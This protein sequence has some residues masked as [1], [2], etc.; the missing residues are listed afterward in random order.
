M[1]LLFSF[2]R[3]NRG[4]YQPLVGPVWSSS[5]DADWTIMKRNHS[6]LCIPV[7]KYIKGGRPALTGI[8]IRMRRGTKQP[9]GT[10]VYGHKGGVHV[11]SGSW[12]AVGWGATSALKFSPSSP[13]EFPSDRLTLLLVHLLKHW[14]FLKF[15]IFPQIVSHIFWC[16]WGFVGDHHV[17][18]A[19]F[20]RSRT[21][22]AVR[23]RRRMGGAHICLF[24]ALSVLLNEICAFSEII[25]VIRELF[26]PPGVGFV[27]YVMYYGQ[28]NSYLIHLF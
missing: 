16:T 22:T 7:S 13:H 1:Y 5:L 12:G 18:W 19:S 26:F 11:W 10:W 21:P 27:I 25:F 9:M 23:V 24:F 20:A 6:Y 2:P 28:G 15:I 3:T 17:Y 8:L 4:K 14:G